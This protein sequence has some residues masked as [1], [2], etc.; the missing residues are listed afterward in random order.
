LVGASTIEP[1]RMWFLFQLAIVLAV[2]QSNVSWHW[3]DHGIGIVG[4][5]LAYLATL[6]VS[7]Q[8]PVIRGEDK[9]VQKR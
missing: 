6:I 5:G 1:R 4:V 3:A 9:P 7:G 8:Q 2:V